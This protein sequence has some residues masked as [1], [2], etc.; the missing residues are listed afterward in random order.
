LSKKTFAAVKAAGGELIVQVKENQ[1]YLCE[2]LY[3][4]GR[5]V[6]PIDT[7]TATE[8]NRNRIETRTVKLFDLKKHISHTKNWDGW[9]E[10]ITGMAVVDRITES[11]DYVSK[12]WKT[13][14][15]QSIYATSYLSNATDIAAKIRGHWGIE[16]HNYVRDETMLEDYSRIRKNPIGFA[17]L[18]SWVLNI[19]RFNGEQN[20][21]AALYR[22]CCSFSRALNYFKL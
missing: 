10:C 11:F 9:D 13:V 7:V 4:A 6:K 2:K 16:S 20:I 17:V 3:K 14:T 19:L 15:E 18:R 12:S 1:K 5:L 8:K 22:N 21:R